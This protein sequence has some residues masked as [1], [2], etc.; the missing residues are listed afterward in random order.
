MNRTEIIDARFKIRNL[1]KIGFM[2][3]Y[4]LSRIDDW[5]SKFLGEPSEK[6]VLSAGGLKKQN[7]SY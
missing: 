4:L 6:E 2:K 1:Q 3:S 7:N 5:S